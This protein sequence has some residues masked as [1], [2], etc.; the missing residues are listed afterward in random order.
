[1]FETRKKAER[2]IKALIKVALASHLG[3]GHNES[4][5]NAKRERSR[6]GDARNS[7]EI[8][9]SKL[10]SHYAVFVAEAT[11]FLIPWFAR[12]LTNCG[13]SL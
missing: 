11:P 12:A 3:S 1:V 4:L 9:G 2:R 13:I 6:D 10:S 5:T 7:V 8:C